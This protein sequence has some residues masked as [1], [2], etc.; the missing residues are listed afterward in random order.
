MEQKQCI[1]EQVISAE[2]SRTVDAIVEEYLRDENV[3]FENEVEL[4]SQNG[5]IMRRI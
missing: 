3:T 5:R 1:R 4:R 2:I